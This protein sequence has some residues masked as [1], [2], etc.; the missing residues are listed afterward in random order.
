MTSFTARPTLGTVIDALGAVAL[1]AVELPRGRDVPIDAVTIHDPGEELSQEPGALVLAIGVGPAERLVELI[2]TLGSSRS[3][4]LIVKGASPLGPEVRAAVRRAGVALLALT[5]AASWFQVT[6]LLRSALDETPALDLG[7]IA[8]VPVGDLF[9]LA[10]AIAD[11]IDAPV[12]IEDRSSRVLAFSRRQDEADSGRVATILGR[13]VPEH[14]LRLLEERDVFSRLAGQTGPVYVEG[15]EQGMLPRLAIA[16][17]S[18]PELLGTI[19]AAVT[20]EPP[21]ETLDAFAGAAR[22]AGL[23]LLRHRGDADLSRRFHSEQLAAVLTGGPAAGEAAQRLG[24]P[25]QPLLVLAAEPT[26]REGT[27]F[28]VAQGRL[29]DVLGMSLAVVHSKTA[30]ARVGTVVYAV[31]PAAG[32]FAGGGER[33]VAVARRVLRRIVERDDV[34]IGV[35]GPAPTV[36]DLARARREADRALHVL[37]HRSEPHGVAHY[38]EVYLESLLVR[39]VETAVEEGEGLR[40]PLQ[41]VR[42]HD[43]E[44][45]KDY[46]RTLACFLELGGDVAACAD[47]LS[48]HANTVRYRLRRIEQISGLDLG[49]PMT[50]ISALV[51]LRAAALTG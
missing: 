46:M 15:V 1:E 10:N 27:D 3:A 47:R 37:R 17:R 20:E 34:V 33:G 24:M 45:G 31:V 9:S 36:R 11:L 23:H 50:R 48:V 14:Y 25:Q 4:G 49:D 44:R 5:P 12:T 51:Q 41:R 6:V 28:E 21:P 8:G 2:D 18:G 22:L 40:G 38:D 35:G 32:M 19:W 29:V 13:Q 7:D 30:T 42:D 16:V 26:G 43:D 39:L